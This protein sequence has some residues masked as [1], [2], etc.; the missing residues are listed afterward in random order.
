MASEAPKSGRAA[1]S[2]P[3]STSEISVQKSTDLRTAKVLGGSLKLPGLKL[4]IY[5]ILVIPLPGLL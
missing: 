5:K 4:E 1:P 3:R 2:D